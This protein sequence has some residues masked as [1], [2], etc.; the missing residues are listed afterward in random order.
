MDFITCLPKSKGF[1]II[2]VVV[3]RLSK[4]AHFMA[5]KPPISARSVAET[6]IREVVRLHGIPKSIV[7]DRDSMFVSSFWKELFAQSGTHLKFSTA[8][9]PETDGQTEVVNRVLETYLRCFT[10]EQPKQW[11]RWVAWA[12]FWYNTSY[13]T[14]AKMTPFEVVYGRAPPTLQ[15]FLPGECRV[16]AVVETLCSRDEVLRR[17]REN[18]LRAQQE[19][20]KQANKHRREVQFEV[21]DR[22]FLKVRPFRRQSLQPGAHHK[23]SAKFFGPFEVLQKVGKVAYRL[24]LPESSR[25][26]PVFHVSQLRRARGDHPVEEELPET[27]ELPI[28]PVLEPEAVLAWRRV[29]RGKGEE[30][31]VLVKWAGQ[32]DDD[33]TWID[34]AN[35]CGQFPDFNLADKVVSKSDG[36]D[37]EGRR[38]EEDEAGVQ[39]LH[40]VHG[41]KPIVV[42]RR[43]K[44][45]T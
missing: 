15:R 43:R 9:H 31:Q 20:T 11:V 40:G 7:S 24:R 45:R 22:V 23:L 12:E 13:Q 41:D 6:F 42:Y 44:A 32:H 19:M 10:S 27:L 8:Y 4:Y 26:H 35:F 5:L 36:I 18:L 38:E 25:I 28:Q 14:A 33:A 39:P 1:S 34:V 3:D 17:L 21:G 30:E 2:L 37:V 29:S 16:A